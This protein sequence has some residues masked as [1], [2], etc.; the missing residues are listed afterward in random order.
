MLETEDVCQAP[1]PLNLGGSES[2]ESS[3]DY[4]MRHGL[5]GLKMFHQK[6]MVFWWSAPKDLAEFPG[7]LA[8][9]NPS[10]GYG[11]SAEDVRR[12]GGGG[13]GAVGRGCLFG[14]KYM[15]CKIFFFINIL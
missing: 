5:E 15:F 7:K 4:L 14:F 10:G 12:V 6:T 11:C 3:S 8:P 1:R 9:G 13:S 2:P